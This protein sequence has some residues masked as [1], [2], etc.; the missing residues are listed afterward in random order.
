MHYGSDCWAMTKQHF[1]RISVAKMRMVRWMNGKTRKCRIRN[2]DMRDN[3]RVVPIEDK[4][5]YDCFWPRIY[6]RIAVRRSDVI[7]TTTRK[8][9]KV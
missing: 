3:K 5:D 8:K 1:D 2:E 7:H 6:E 9:E 4:T